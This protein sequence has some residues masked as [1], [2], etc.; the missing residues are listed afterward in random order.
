MRPPRRLPRRP[1]AAP[2]AINAVAQYATISSEGNGVGYTLPTPILLEPFE[3]LTGFS[4]TAGSPTLAIN[5][6]REV[7]GSG[8]LTVVATS[9]TAPQVTK[10][11]IGTF[12]PSQMGVIA[13]YVDFNNETAFQDL[14]GIDFRLGQA[15]TYYTASG[16]T[17][18]TGLSETTFGGYWRSFNVSEVATLRDLTSAT[19]GLRITT[20]HAAPYGETPAIDCGM[21]NCAGRPIIILTFDDIRPEQET[22]AYPLMAARGF[23]G[24][25]YVPTSLVDQ[26][27]R[28]TLTQ[29]RTLDAAG[30]DMALDG[31]NDD[32]SM[33][34][35]ADPAAC[36]TEIQAMQAWLVSNG[37]NPRAKDHICYPNGTRLVA[38]TEVQ[39]SAGI[40]TNG[41]T[42]VT[43]TDTSS[44][45]GGSVMQF[46]GNPALVQ[47]G[48]MIVSVDSGTQITL[49]KTVGAGLTTF[50]ATNV[51]GPFQT[52]KLATALANAG[53]KSARGVNNGVTYSRFG[54]G[55][56]RALNMP[57]NSGSAGVA[58][59]L[60]AYVDQAILRGSTAIFYF[61]AVTDAGGGLN[62]TVAEFTAFLD[63]L[64]SRIN[65][66]SVMT[67]SQWWDSFE[68][69]PF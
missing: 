52:G 26:A 44:L 55:Y 19:T 37:L 24:S 1:A 31:T 45:L 28:L 10:S 54:P 30:W 56:G 47:S 40:V 4:G 50:K 42:T 17:G 41:T 5:A 9:S 25:L 58:T 27:D 35:R 29:L 3:S 49:D 59:D 15:G 14:T 62:I 63:G 68:E 61:H 16:I 43:M 57:G 65:D 46:T 2:Y 21:A 11:D 48:T 64:V 34:T 23:K 39:K 6:T 60:L 22:V 38:G 33:T 51:S 12:N 69:I 8:C 32:T 18:F 20:S 13:Y 7:Q 66:I 53:I 36:V 67:L